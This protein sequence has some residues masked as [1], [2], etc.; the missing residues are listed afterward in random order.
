MKD[1]LFDDTLSVGVDEID[2]DHSRLVD[3]YNILSHAV[4]ENESPNYVEAIL[5]ELVS[6]TAWHFK[7]EERL[8]IKYAFNGY[9]DH[10]AEHEGLVDDAR[11][12]QK[13][14]REAGKVLSADDIE[15]LEKW[16]TMH[17]LSTDNRLGEFLM[18]AM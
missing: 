4:E 3:L 2:A 14:F 6:L 10:K 16:L 8:M 1:I 12:L 7:H 9:D 11:E 13:K 17:I 18:T 15:Y 5:E